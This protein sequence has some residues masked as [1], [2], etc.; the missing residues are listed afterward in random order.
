MEIW[1]QSIIMTLIDNSY[2]EK[3]QTIEY[4][5]NAESKLNFKGYSSLQFSM[6]MEVYSETF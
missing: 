2:M 5:N 6:K 1:S 3:F 4:Y